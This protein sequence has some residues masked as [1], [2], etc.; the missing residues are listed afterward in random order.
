[1]ECLRKA[2]QPGADDEVARDVTRA[3]RFMRLYAEQVKA[4]NHHRGLTRRTVIRPIF[5]EAG[6]D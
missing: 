3:L 4:L 1:M 2:T 6:D 5:A